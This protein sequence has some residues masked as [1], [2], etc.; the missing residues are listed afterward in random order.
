MAESPK[1]KHRANGKPIGGVRKG[2]GRKLG[3]TNTLPLGAVQAIKA[4]RLRV[5]EGISEPLAEVADEA[6]EAVVSVMRMDF[7]DPAAAQARLRAAAMV[8]EEI[9]GPVKQRVEHSFSDMTDEQLEAKFLAL[10]TKAES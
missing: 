9:C 6:F 2:A 4:M 8:R 1:R 10:T 5:P 3:D 7:F